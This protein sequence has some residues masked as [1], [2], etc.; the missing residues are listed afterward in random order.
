MN[1]DKWTTK[2]EASHNSYQG[3]SVNYNHITISLVLNMVI[4]IVWSF[5]YTKK[6]Y[7]C[8]VRLVSKFSLYQNNVIFD[9][10]VFCCCCRRF[11]SFTQFSGYYSD[12]VQKELVMA[13]KKKM[14]TLG[15]ES[16]DIDTLT[17]E[18]VVYSYVSGER[19][20]LLGAWC[21]LVCVS[22]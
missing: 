15:K 6:C 10:Q 19:I 7:V 2:A 21:E 18:I 20:D 8:L 4:D 3:L 11:P 12:S 22:V 16:I 9:L 17:L 1:D 14:K 13:K 5:V